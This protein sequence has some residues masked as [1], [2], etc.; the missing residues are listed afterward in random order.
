MSEPFEAAQDQGSFR[1]IT[2]IFAF[3]S[4]FFPLEICMFST[5]HYNR[6]EANCK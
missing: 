5:L 2:E 4:S 6:C 1:L 3:F